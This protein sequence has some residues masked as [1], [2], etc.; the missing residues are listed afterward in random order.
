MEKAV[1]YCSVFAIAASFCKSKERIAAFVLLVKMLGGN[2]EILKSCQR[3]DLVQDSGSGFKVLLAG[4]SGCCLIS[5]GLPGVRIK[6]P[7]PRC[8]T[9]CRG[10]PVF[11]EEVV[12]CQTPFEGV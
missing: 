3:F 1:S 10:S 6:I 8:Q 7:T 5:A 9:A 12:R 11:P 2:L 4:F